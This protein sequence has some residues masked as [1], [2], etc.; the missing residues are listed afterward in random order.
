[1]KKIYGLF[2][3]TMM[4]VLV[5]GIVSA[6]TPAPYNRPCAEVD[7]C[8]WTTVSTQATGNL[9]LGSPD[10]SNCRLNFNT[11]WPVGTNEAPS[12]AT[13]TCIINSDNVESAILYLSI[14][15]DIINCTLNGEKVFSAT[16]HEN[17]APV[18]PM[19]GG[20]SKSLTIANG[21][22]TLVCTVAD[23]G[24]MSHFDA[25]VVPT[26]T[27]TVPEFGAV[28]GVLTVLGALGVF[29]IVRKK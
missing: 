18:N 4:I 14:D 7:L 17:C 16:S 13:A 2:M 25:C 23:R 11:Y 26:T 19:V 21:R 22:N 20:Y 27:P 8:T 6:A 1:M 29:F 3:L 15:N 10:N 12:L 5:S 9:P 28:A 24:V